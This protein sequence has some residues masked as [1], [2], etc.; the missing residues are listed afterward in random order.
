MT[1]TDFFLMV[2][3]L[4]LHEI[5]SRHLFEQW[6]PLHFFSPP[7]QELAVGFHVAE[8]HSQVLEILLKAQ[9]FSGLTI[10]LSDEDEFIRLLGHFSEAGDAEG[11]GSV[12]RGRVVTI[13]SWKDRM[14]FAMELEA[15]EDPVM[16]HAFDSDSDVSNVNGNDEGD[17]LDSDD[18]DDDEEYHELAVLLD[19]VPLHLP[20]QLSEQDGIFPTFRD[21]VNQCLY[22]RLDLPFASAYGSYV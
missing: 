7:P 14:K 12:Y 16:D 19:L 21:R 22:E 17:N 15:A 20:L 9:I 11:T 5:F 6:F 1:D 2:T 18:D 4:E 8:S 3:G 13:E 10:F